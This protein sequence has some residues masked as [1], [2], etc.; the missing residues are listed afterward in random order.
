MSDRVCVR[1]CT[2]HGIHYATC[3]DYG[4]AEAFEKAKAAGVEGVSYVPQCWGCA[5]QECREGSLVCDRCFG[6][7]RR[8]LDDAPDLLARLRSIVDPSK[9]TP[10]DRQPGGGTRS[11]PAAAVASDPLDAILCVEEVL[12]AWAR[13]GR[14]LPGISNNLEVVTWM[15]RHVLDRHKPHSGED[16]P[17]RA[18]L[19]DAWSVQD[20]VDQWGVE[21]VPAKGEKPWEDE[22]ERDI[23]VTDTHEWGNR[24]ITREQAQ[25]IA[26]SQQ[27]LS[28]WE[29][30]GLIEVEGRVILGDGK[31]MSFFRENKVREVAQQ[32]AARVG[33]PRKDQAE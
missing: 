19:R 29:R 1:G 33:R 15:G 28:R 27:T 3:A 10:S 7:M 14:D 21:R 32:M 16:E 17:W 13:W 11:E 22:V 23:I 8:L 24:L 6:R 18:G 26:G 31:P 20:A 5:P 2:K 25:E 9:A 4:K 12:D 30:K